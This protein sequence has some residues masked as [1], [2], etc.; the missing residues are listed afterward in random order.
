MDRRT[1]SYYERHTAE[2]PSQ[3]LEVTICDLKLA[4]SSDV[5][6]QV[7]VRATADPSAFLD[8]G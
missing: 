7:H 8:P 1:L 2:L 6:Q 5:R 4:A 3:E